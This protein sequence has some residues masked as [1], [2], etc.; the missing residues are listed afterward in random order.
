MSE[1]SETLGWL[2]MQHTLDK[3]MFTFRPLTYDAIGLSPCLISK[4]SPCTAGA[5][6][7]EGLIP[8]LERPLE[9]GMATHSSILA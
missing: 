4:E 3:F 2:V 7:D 6:G 5:T 9:N 8:G 1:A